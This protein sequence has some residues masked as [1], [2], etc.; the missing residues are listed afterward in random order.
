MDTAPLLFF[1]RPLRMPLVETLDSLRS[2]ALY[3][4]SK[5]DLPSSHL[6]SRKAPADRIHDVNV[7]LLCKWKDEKLNALLQCPT[8]SMFH[9]VDVH[10]SV[11]CCRSAPFSFG[12]RGE[13]LRQWQHQACH[14][15]TTSHMIHMMQRRVIYVYTYIHICICIHIPCIIMHNSILYSLQLDFNKL[16]IWRFKTRIK[17]EFYI[18]FFSLSC[19]VTKILSF[20]WLKKNG[21]RMFVEN[22]RI[23]SRWASFRLWSGLKQLWREALSVRA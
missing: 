18:G 10:V 13:S 19:W 2:T 22:S 15:K 14:A 6:H 17:S 20:T 1:Q 3:N 7:H 21:Y 4:F 8:G 9:L 23:H 12:V 16:H 5:S 11:F